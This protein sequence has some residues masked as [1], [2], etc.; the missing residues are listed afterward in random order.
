MNNRRARRDQLWA[1]PAARPQ[2][3]TRAPEPTILLHH[4]FSGKVVTARKSYRCNCCGKPI[5][6]GDQYQRD[7]VKVLI[8]GW[9]EELKPFFLCGAC[10][11]KSDLAQAAARAL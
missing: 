1:R 11:Q 10:R 3:R 6:P 8:G 2:P 9:K 7:V 5:N 4:V